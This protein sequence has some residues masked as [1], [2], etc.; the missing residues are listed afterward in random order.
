MIV[1]KNK[2]IQLM[3]P[4]QMFRE[5]QIN[6]EYLNVLLQFVKTLLKNVNV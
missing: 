5:L 1:K 3:N 6:L 2:P 4:F